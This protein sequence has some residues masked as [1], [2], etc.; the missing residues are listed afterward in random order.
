MKGAERGKGGWGGEG[1]NEMNYIGLCNSTA[2][3]YVIQR[4]YDGLVVEFIRVV[5]DTVSN[6]ASNCYKCSLCDDSIRI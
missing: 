1:R 2:Y 6:S 4:H 5:F 3:T